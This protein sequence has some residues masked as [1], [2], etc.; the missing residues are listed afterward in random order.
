MHGCQID[1]DKEQFICIISEYIAKLPIVFLRVNHTGYDPMELPLCCTSRPFTI[2]SMLFNSVGELVRFSRDGGVVGDIEIGRVG[3]EDIERKARITTMTFEKPDYM[4]CIQL[5]AERNLLLNKI[6][7][8]RYTLFEKMKKI[9]TNVEKVT[10]R[11]ERRYSSVKDNIIVMLD[12]ASL[13][14]VWGGF[15]PLSHRLANFKTMR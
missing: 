7:L 14:G 4:D 12:F 15:R 3:G 8:K 5:T 2:F 11:T 10:K 9:I 13:E 6:T 1:S